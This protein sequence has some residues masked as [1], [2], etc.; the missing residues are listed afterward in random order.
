TCKEGV[1][2]LIEIGFV[3]KTAQ[4]SQYPGLYLFSNPSRMMR[5]VYNLKT[6]T[7]EIIGSFEQ[8]YMDIC[9]VGE[10]MIP[11]VTTHQELTETCMLS[12][13][14][15]QIPFSDF[16]QSPR[17]MYCCQMGKQTMGTPSHTLKYRSDQKMYSVN[18]P[19]TPLV[20]SSTHDYYHM[21]DYP[22]G[23]NAVVAVISYTG[24]DME[25]A[26]VLNKA[27]VERGFGHGNIQK[28]VIINLREIGGARGT[29]VIYQFGYGDGSELSEKLDADGLPY[30]GTIVQFDDPICCY[31]NVATKEQ[32][33]E[34][35]KSTE[36]AFITDV[37]ILGSD[38]GKDILQKV[39]ISF[40]IPRRPIMGDKFANRH[41]QKGI[42]SILWPQ[43]NMPFT[44]GGLTP[45]IIFNPHGYPSRM[46]IGMMIETLAGKSGSN[47]GVIHDCTP[48]MFSEDNTASDYYGKLLEASG[49]NYFGTERMYSGVDGRELKADI[50]VGVI[51]YIRL[52]HMVGD[53]YQVR[54]TG[55][56]DQLTRQPVQGRKRCG[57]I[58]F[59]EMERDSLLAHGVSFL[60][61]DRLFSQSDESL[62][63]LCSNCGSMVTIQKVKKDY[64][65]IGVK[66]CR[67]C[68]SGDYVTPVSVP[69]VLQYLM[70]ELASVNIKLEFELNL[71]RS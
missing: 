42:C 18:S 45:D 62:A 12:V 52:R 64:K 54:S 49:Y 8:V 25:D 55:P 24:Y 7:V 60:L 17:N 6:E 71:N 30:I 63:H 61:R 26:L 15:S 31:Y 5:P 40:Y 57:G 23:T 16:N 2:S 27:A 67:N 9:V 65:E 47:H 20:R 19:Q 59:G 22:F 29:E 13:I 41:G 4:A 43:E 37:K 70:A 68:K 48:F 11:N 69:Y 56:I 36:V 35:Y 44:E 10:E 53:K 58:R 39:A 38:N 34:K 66:V 33:V 14:A 32:K 28:T 50:F 1:D 21:D 51:Y 46:T 3:P